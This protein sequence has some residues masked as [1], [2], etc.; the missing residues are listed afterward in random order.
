MKFFRTNLD[1]IIISLFE[2]ITGVLLMIKPVQFT[3]GIII[4]AGV[5]LIIL[6]LTSVIKYFYSTAAEG[7]ISQSL[8][9][10]I[11]TMLIGIFCAFNHKWFISTFPVLT[12]IY[13]VVVLLAGI[14]QIQLTA[15]SIRLRLGRWFIPAIS[16]LVSVV[17][18]VIIIANPFASTTVLWYLIGAAIIVEAI[19]DIIGII[20]SACRNR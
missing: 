15:D 4:F 9:K 5:V 6:G 20:V 17:L 11:L 7:V 14:H 12:V 3:S 16:A 1:G 19:F 10:G 18:G 2:I 8:F 13:G